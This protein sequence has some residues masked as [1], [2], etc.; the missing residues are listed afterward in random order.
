MT[1]TRVETGDRLGLQLKGKPVQR[2]GRPGDDRWAEPT[3]V[4]C[5]RPWI[6]IP[7][8]VTGHNS[9]NL[10]STSP[11]RRGGQTNPKEEDLLGNLLGV[12]AF[13]QR[14]LCARWS[15]PYNPGRMD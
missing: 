12:N 3:S 7:T 14:V 1:A 4:P 6:D 2:K 13:A 10:P 9:E 5:P 11:V 15:I 8:V